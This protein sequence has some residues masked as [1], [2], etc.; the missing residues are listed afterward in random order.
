MNGTRTDE[1]CT[2]ERTSARTRLLVRHAPALLPGPLTAARE[3]SRAL[4]SLAREVAARLN[5]ARLPRRRGA[6]GRA[7]AAAWLPRLAFGHK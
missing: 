6:L 4:D 5:E 2:I 3:R 1:F 7:A